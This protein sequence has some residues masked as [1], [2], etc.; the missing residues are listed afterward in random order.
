MV[1]DEIIKKTAKNVIENSF[2]SWKKNKLKKGIDTSHLLL[3]VIAPNERLVATIVQSLQTSLGQKLWEKLT[4]ELAVQNSFEICL[5]LWLTTNDT[6]QQPFIYM[7]CPLVYLNSSKQSSVKSKMSW[8]IIFLNF[9][10]IIM[11]HMK[12][13]SLTPVYRIGFV[14][15]E[16]AHA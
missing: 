6:Q 9:N 8:K 7:R 10:L 12:L 11:S 5:F 1:S 15:D 2:S 14:S 3:D 13:Y 16:S 4:I